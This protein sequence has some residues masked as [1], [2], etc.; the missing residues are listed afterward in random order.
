MKDLDLLPVLPPEPTC[1]A[2]FPIA[3]ASRGQ[4]GV[5]CREM[6][7]DQEADAGL[8]MTAGQLE[9]VREGEG[10]VYL[11]VKADP[12]TVV[13]LCH[14]SGVPVVTNDD[15]QGRPSYTYCPTWQTAR[16]RHAE[17]KHGLTDRVVA[18]PTSMG[19]SSLD[20]DDPWGE[21]MRG[22]QELAG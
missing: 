15:G 10:G 11:N 7:A 9:K 13:M 3:G 21:A 17:G 8:D 14:G 18:E 20:A 1:P 4:R 6:Q 2:A 5:V 12:S 16:D 22:L 19:V